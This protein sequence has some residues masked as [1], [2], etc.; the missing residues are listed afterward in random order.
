M[1]YPPVSS[2]ASLVGCGS[3]SLC[4]IFLRS[5]LNVRTATFSLL[6][7]ILGSATAFGQSSSQGLQLTG[8]W[9]SRTWSTS[10]S[11]R[12]DPVVVINE[13]EPSSAISPDS[14]FT[15]Q[16]RSGIEGVTL[17][18]GTGLYSKPFEM[19]DQCRSLQIP[20]SYA[21]A[22]A[23]VGRSKANPSAAVFLDITDK[24]GRVVLARMLGHQALSPESDK[25][26]SS[27]SMTATVSEH[28]SLWNLEGRAVAFGELLGRTV[29]V[30]LTLATDPVVPQTA[31]N[32]GY[33]DAVPVGKE[34]ARSID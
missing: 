23:P 32:V 14:A 22:F 5:D 29:R 18:N 28:S 16:T 26:D 7:L 8:N 27:L 2:G 3:R 34:G 30:R 17:Y 15:D 19:H 21:A 25:M 9:S 13:G 4:Q 6:C 12:L 20:I 10:L 11:L 33:V 1:I 24:T 31:L